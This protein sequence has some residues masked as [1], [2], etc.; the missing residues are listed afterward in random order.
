MVV[1]D[2]RSVTLEGE[3][4]LPSFMQEMKQ[5]GQRGRGLYSKA[6]TLAK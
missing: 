5:R 6:V 1:A 2:F 3:M 4:D